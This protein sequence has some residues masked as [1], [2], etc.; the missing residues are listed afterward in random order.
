MGRPACFGSCCVIVVVEHATRGNVAVANTGGPVSARGSSGH[1]A[2]ALT[3]PGSIRRYHVSPFSLSAPACCPGPA[4]PRR[5]VQRGGEQMKKKKSL[6]QHCATIDSLARH[7]TRGTASSTV[8]GAAFD[9]AAFIATSQRRSLP[10]Q[11]K[12]GLCCAQARATRS[13]G[14]WPNATGP[15]ARIP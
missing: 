11:A 14:I 1:G 15:L 5:G 10:P 7:P 2:A 3:R 8:W 12:P 4:S 13:S 6:E 9:A